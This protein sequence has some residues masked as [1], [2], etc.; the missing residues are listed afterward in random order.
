MDTLQDTIQRYR[1]GNAI[2]TRVTDLILPEVPSDYLFPDRD[3]S[4]LTHDRPRWIGAEN[5][6]GDGQ[7]VALSIHSWI[8]QTDRH[9]ILIDT[10]VGS[11]KSRPLN[12]IFDQLDTPYLER[13]AAAGVQPGDVD[14]VLITHLHIDHVGWNTLRHGDRWVPAFPNARYIFSEAEY[15]FYADE[16]NV[17]TP[18]AGVFADSVQP[19]VDAGQAVLINAADRLPVEGFSFHSSKGHSF[20]HVSIS[21]TS[22]GERALFSGDVMHHPVQVARP[23]W[24]SVFCEFEGDAQTSRLWALNYAADHRATFFSSHFPGSSVGVVERDDTGFVWTPV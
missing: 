2:V 20:D 10:G 16:E 9:T 21:L 24:N 17:K 6:S 7:S 15:R 4:V 1:V 22:G 19:I 18:S 3:R 8:V 14:F 23:E 12:P 13:L 11:G 5:T